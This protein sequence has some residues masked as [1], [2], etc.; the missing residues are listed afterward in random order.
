MTLFRRCRVVLTIAVVSLVLGAC[1]P[2]AYVVLLPNPD[3]TTGRII[4]T[5]P[6]GEAEIA[7]AGQAASL[8]KARP[9][10]FQLSDSE[11]EKT[12][13]GAL[14]AQPVSPAVFVL[15]FELGGTRLTPESEALLSEVLA[16][17]SRRPGADISIVGHTDTAGG[18]EENRWLGLERAEFVRGR[19]VADGLDLE[20]V[21]T[22]SHGEGNPL[23]A[24]ADN[25]L[26]PRNRRVEITVR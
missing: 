25:V 3:G 22:A 12:F 23:V 9:E 10:T 19:V 13:S 6:E 7:E 2:K 14:Q 5:G 11:I 1:A 18:A 17:V 8:D 24:T 4:V 21:E 16:E 20:R 26:E 15:Y